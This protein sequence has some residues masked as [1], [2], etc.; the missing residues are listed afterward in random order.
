MITSATRWS[1]RCFYLAA[2]GEPSEQ[3]SYG[4]LRTNCCFTMTPSVLHPAATC[5]LARSNLGQNSHRDWYRALKGSV[6]IG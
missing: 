2:L 4:I 1:I 6:Y 5:N 3:T